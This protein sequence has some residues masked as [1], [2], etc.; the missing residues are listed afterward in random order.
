VQHLNNEEEG[1]L[2]NAKLQHNFLP[3]RDDQVVVSKSGKRTPS[4]HYSLPAA[5]C[6]EYRVDLH[7]MHCLCHY[8]L[9]LL[10]LL[11][12]H[13]MTGDLDYLLD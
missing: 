8:F 4:F 5:N 1:T 12:L 9:I 11:L 7:D 10:L 13:Y 3:G 2:S 6:Y